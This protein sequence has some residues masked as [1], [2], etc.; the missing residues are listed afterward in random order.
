MLLCLMGYTQNRDTE[1]IQRNA[2]LV[3]DVGSYTE[4]GNSFSWGL[5][6]HDGYYRIM[7]RNSTYMYTN[8]YAEEALAERADP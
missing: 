1:S 5:C 3:S 7:Y 4:M 2:L 8:A 6:W